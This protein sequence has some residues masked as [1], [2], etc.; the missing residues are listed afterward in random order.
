MPPRAFSDGTP[1][2][3]PRFTQPG[4]RARSPGTFEGTS[5]NELPRTMAYSDFFSC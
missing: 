4:T 2:N 3:L 1:S 5:G